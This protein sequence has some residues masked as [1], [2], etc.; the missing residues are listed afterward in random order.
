MLRPTVSALAFALVL[1]LAASDTRAQ[2]TF[3]LVELAPNVHIALV[4]RNPPRYVFANALVVIRERDV[5]VVDTH[6][7]PSAARVLI[8]EI[9]RLTPLPVRYVVNTHWHGDHVYGNQ[10]YAERFPEVEFLGHLNTR[11]DVE[12]KGSEALRK[13]IADLPGS[14]AAREGWLTTGQGPNGEDLTPAQVEQ[15]RRSH[16]LRSEYLEELKGLRLTPPNVTFEDR[17][18]LSDSSVPVE[19]IHFGPAHTRGDVV[20]YLPEQGILA[21]GD[22]LEDGLPWVDENS[23]PEGWATVLERLSEIDAEI[24]VPAH[25]PVLR[26]RGLLDGERDF[27]R[28]AADVAARALEDGLS[29]EATLERLDFSTFRWFLDPE[30]ARRGEPFREYVRG[31]VTRAYEVGA[32]GSMDPK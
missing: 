10:S 20:V 23:T 31:V 29:L 28:A 8:D 4:T 30:D 3:T 18:M 12:T 15:V 25:G 11:V 1:C 21:V 26:D 27:M 17:L 9:A 16:R 32:A 19:L 7:S 13:E 22:L 24:I 6:Q 5:L 14:I 2:D